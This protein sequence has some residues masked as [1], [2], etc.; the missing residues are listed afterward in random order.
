MGLDE[1]EPSGG[2]ARGR[3][4]AGHISHVVLTGTSVSQSPVTNPQSSL[5]AG[6]IRSIEPGSLAASLCLRH[7]D[8]ILAVNGHPVEDVIDVQ[9]YAAED[10]VE[11]VYR[12]DGTQY[13]SR[14]TRKLGQA[15]GIED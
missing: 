12:R 8:E 5:Y 3:S 13:A 4:A 15:L 11:I 9:F 14:T 2:S 1:P 10:E 7:G 6:L